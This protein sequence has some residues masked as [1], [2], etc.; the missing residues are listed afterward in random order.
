MMCLKAVIFHGKSSCFKTETRCFCFS[1]NYICFLLGFFYPSFPETWFKSNPWLELILESDFSLGSLTWVVAVP[2]LDGKSFLA[3]KSKNLVFWIPNILL[4]VD[5]APRA[6]VWRQS[7]LS[8]AQDIRAGCCE[9]SQAVGWHGMNTLQYFPAKILR[10]FGIGR[11]TTN[12]RAEFPSFPFS[13]FFQTWNT[14]ELFQ[15]LKTPLSL[16]F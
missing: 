2:L 8:D 10:T 4:V 7:E 1:P 5:P 9:R 16:V 3:E 12:I 14:K 15:L 11:E 6:D 13:S